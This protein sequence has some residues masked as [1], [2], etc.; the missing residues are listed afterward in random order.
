M[1]KP[2]SFVL[3]VCVFVA[4]FA[5]VFCLSAHE[6]VKNNGIYYYIV[7]YGK[8]TVTDTV[9][10][11]LGDYVVPS[12]IGG[13]PVIAIKDNVFYNDRRLTAIVISNN[14]TTIG[15]NAF[16]GCV[17]LSS[18]TIGEDVT[19]IGE[20]AFYGCCNLTSI[21]L[22]ASVSDI[23]KKAF[24]KCAENFI[25]YGYYNSFARTYAEANGYQFEALDKLIG[26]LDHSG[27]VS[28]NDIT[29]LAKYISG[30]DTEIDAARAD[31]DGDT[32]ISLNDL[33]FLTRSVAG[34]AVSSE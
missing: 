23:G 15:K 12:T 31:C 25:I 17:Q 24:S 21:V 28:I 14:V 13:Y 29:L 26:D 7:S 1:K 34:W 6:A 11:A 27:D 5:S 20:G 8:A 10:E 3:A 30:W 18:A 22:P 33:T 4:F 9:N 16:S 32:K 2:L 19:T